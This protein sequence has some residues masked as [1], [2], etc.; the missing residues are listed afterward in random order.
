[1]FTSEENRGSRRTFDTKYGSDGKFRRN[2]HAIDLDY[3]EIS[4]ASPEKSG[5]FTS[6]HKPEE[7]NACY[8][9]LFGWNNSWIQ[10]HSFGN[11]VT[12]AWKEAYNEERIQNWRSTS[13]REVLFWNFH[14]WGPQT[15]HHLVKG[16]SFQNYCFLKPQSV[17]PYQFD[18]QDIKSEGTTEN[19]TFLLKKTK[20]SKSN[21]NFNQ[22]SFSS[23]ES[24]F[25]QG[26]KFRY[27][28][29]L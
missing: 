3:G 29:Y 10:P 28:P 5:R 8:S 9:D 23:N 14:F 12:F 17:T 11:A 25:R 19:E 27:K 24:H 22:I 20:H 7:E 26:L 4:A 1:M 16:G 6:C 18:R 21:V 15:R 13:A 2:N